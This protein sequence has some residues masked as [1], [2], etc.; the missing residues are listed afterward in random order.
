[1]PSESLPG[2]SYDEEP[3][4]RVELTGLEQLRNLV[5]LAKEGGRGPLAQPL[6]AIQMPEDGAGAQDMAAGLEQDPLAGEGEVSDEELLEGPAGKQVELPSD[7]LVNGVIEDPSEPSGSADQSES[8]KPSESSESSKSFESFESSKSAESSES[9]ESSEPSKTDLATGTQTPLGSLGAYLYQHRSR[10]TSAAV[11][12][13]AVA[14]SAHLDVL[15]SAEQLAAALAAAVEHDYAGTLSSGVQ[16]CQA[17]A[18][19]LAEYDY[20]AAVAYC[21]EQAQGALF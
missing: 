4:A 15:P 20:S 9:S 7:E 2:E 1:M 6:H 19:L 13:G 16:L 14:L 12:I 3:G 5:R 17:A 8:P 18:G 11:G 21:L 10:V